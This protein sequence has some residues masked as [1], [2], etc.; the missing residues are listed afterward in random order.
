MSR[1][2]TADSPVLDSG[3]QLNMKT[4]D[5]LARITHDPQVMGK[6]PCIRGMRITV[7]TIVG[8]LASKRSLDDVPAAYP[9]LEREDVFA[10][11]SFAAWRAEEI[12]LPLTG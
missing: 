3:G 1:D 10:A 4:P 2:P 6:K 9:Y 7:G 12:D 8:L 11:L 5:G